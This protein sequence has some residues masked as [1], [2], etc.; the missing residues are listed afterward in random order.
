MYKKSQNKYLFVLF[1]LVI[2]LII[3]ILIIAVYNTRGKNLEEYKIS[4]NSIVYDE[5]YSY[6]KLDKDGVLKREWDNNYYLYSN[7]GNK[8]SLGNTPVFYDKVNNQ[9]TMYGT[10]YQVFTNSDIIQKT[11][12]TT[13]SNLSDFQFFKLND[14][15]YVIIG[16]K[17]IGIDINTSGYLIVSIDKAGN[18]LLIND[19]MNIKTINPLILSVANVKFDIAQEK[20]IVG[21]SE[22]DLKKINGST[23]EYVKKDD[24]SDSNMDKPSIDKSDDNSTTNNGSNN[25]QIYNDILNQIISISGFLPGL[26]TGNE[27]YKNIGL[28]SVVPASSYIDVTYSIIDPEN[29]YL[30]VFLTLTDENNN[31]TY[32][33]LNKDSSYI[34]ITNLKPNKQ[35]NLTLEYK[36]SGSSESVISDKVTVLTNN[37]STKVKIVQIDNENIKY[38]VKTYSEYEFQSADVVL[39]DCN[40]H[41]LYGPTSISGEDATNGYSGVM[42]I[43]TIKSNAGSDSLNWICLKLD[44]VKGTN[45]ESTTINSYHK[46]KIG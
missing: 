9:I 18:A 5:N 39:T 45:S 12:K 32:Y 22:I 15:K 7:D 13:I 28:K 30:S 35:Y 37:N 16:E 31:T 44:N 29:K 3:A 21:D 41:L 43:D 25:S 10:I 42:S 11:E 33:N 24:T 4:L 14:R 26:S 23:N 40:G 6:V 27:L 20:L 2:L 1:I 36:Q 46:I 17:I 34:K 8:Y 19:E 38:L